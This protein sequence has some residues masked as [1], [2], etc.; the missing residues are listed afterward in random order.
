MLRSLNTLP[1]RLMMVSSGHQSLSASNRR[2]TPTIEVTFLKSSS[3]FAN[4]P[5]PKW[6]ARCRFVNPIIGLSVVKA[7]TYNDRDDWIDGSDSF[8]IQPHCGTACISPP[9]RFASISLSWGQ[10]TTENNSKSIDVTI[11]SRQRSSVNELNSSFVRVNLI[12]NPS[13]L[14]QQSFVCKVCDGTDANRNSIR[15]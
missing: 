9:G 7:S 14:D 12:K 3:L 15:Q 2:L 4:N 13:W 11:G 5:G 10:H 8:K 6:P 1:F